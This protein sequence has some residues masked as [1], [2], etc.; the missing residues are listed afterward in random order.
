MEGPAHEIFSAGMMTYMKVA[1][2]LKS[3]CQFVHSL[4]LK[5]HITK[6]APTF[7]VEDLL[8]APSDEILLVLMGGTDGRRDH[9][10]TVYDGLIFDANETREACCCVKKTWITVAPMLPYN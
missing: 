7:S 8:T 9:C 5:F 3:L 10:I 1:L 4:R 6:F 2:P